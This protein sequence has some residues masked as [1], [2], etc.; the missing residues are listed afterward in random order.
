MPI[1]D[2]IVGPETLA[3]S[4]DT[5]MVCEALG[6]PTLHRHHIDRDITVV[7]P[8]ES[9]HAPV[10]RELREELRSPVAGQSGRIASVP[11]GDVDI[12]GIDESDLVYMYIRKP[13]KPGF[14]SED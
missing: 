11:G 6:F 4:L 2:D 13:E 8:R 10:R 12:P 3:G 9:D 5:G 14:F 1:H 7:L